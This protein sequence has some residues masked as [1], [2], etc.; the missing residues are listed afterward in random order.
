M[1][2]YIDLVEQSIMVRNSLVK[3]EPSL[4]GMTE[5]MKE[6]EEKTLAKGFAI[7]HFTRY[8][9][10]SGYCLMLEDF[11]DEIREDALFWSK[12]FSDSLKAVD[13]VIANV[14][15]DSLYYYLLRKDPDRIMLE[16]AT[17]ELK[18]YIK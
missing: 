12:L 3:A 4:T 1:V 11:G 15:V 16:K 6:V 13:K 17:E 18:K 2:K 8:R 5:A 14:E 7:H 9:G 10:Y